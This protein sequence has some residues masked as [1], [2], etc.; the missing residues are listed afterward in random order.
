MIVLLLTRTVYYLVFRYGQNFELN[1]KEIDND[2]LIFIYIEEIIFNLMIFYNLVLKEQNKE[3]F[4]DEIRAASA[5]NRMIAIDD[6]ATRGE[7]SIN[8]HR[9]S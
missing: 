1:S 5:Y 8:N 9:L 7:G 6:E 2:Q 3:H 4:K